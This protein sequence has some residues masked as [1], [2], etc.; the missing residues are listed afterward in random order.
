M[1]FS[2]IGKLSFT[3]YTT[4]PENYPTVWNAVARSNVKGQKSVKHRK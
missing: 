4:V 3:T 2:F 1:L